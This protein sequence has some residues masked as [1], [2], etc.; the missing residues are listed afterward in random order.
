MSWYEPDDPPEL[1]DGW[2]S[3]DEVEEIRALLKH[4]ELQHRPGNRSDAALILIDQ[5]INP[6]RV[7]APGDPPEDPVVTW[8][9]I[10][11][12]DVI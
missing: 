7:G 3:D 2:L 11:L 10:L 1:P 5:I 9:K 6:P 8:A 12:K 4:V